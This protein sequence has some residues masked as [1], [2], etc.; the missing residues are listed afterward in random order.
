MLAWSSSDAYA[1]DCRV[2]GHVELV[3]ARLSDH[4]NSTLE[5]HIRDAQL[6]DL[7]DGHVVAMPELTV[8]HEEICA[9]VASGP[10]GDAGTSAEHPD[11]PVSRSRSGRTEFL[12][13]CTGRRRRTR[14]P[15]FCGARRGC[16]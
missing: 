13:R 12:G 4:L 3:E 6:E 10:R 11:G 7:A 8:G 1:A 5:L 2:Y 16:Q 9:V 14:S 15:R